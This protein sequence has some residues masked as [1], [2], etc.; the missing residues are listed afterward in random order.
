MIVGY[1]VLFGFGFITIPFK[2]DDKGL[3]FKDFGRYYTHF[4]PI[5]EAD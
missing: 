4:V 5:K 3:L 2:I 1:P